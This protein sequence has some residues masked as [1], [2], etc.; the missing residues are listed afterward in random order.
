LPSAAGAGYADEGRLP[1]AKVLV[2]SVHDR[3]DEDEHRVVLAGRFGRRDDV[4]GLLDEGRAR[5]DA[6]RFSF[7]RGRRRFVASAGRLGGAGGRRARPRLLSVA[8]RIRSAK[9]A[10][11][12]P[13]GAS[14]SPKAVF[15]SATGSWG[16]IRGSAVRRLLPSAHL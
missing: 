15:S 12:S 3:G 14:P 1:S 6:G 7:A 8:V 13:K 9:D 5:L 11:L 16:P 10:L 4:V 2:P